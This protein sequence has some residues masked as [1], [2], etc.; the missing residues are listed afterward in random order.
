MVWIPAGEQF[1]MGSP[2]D[3]PR[4][5]GDEGL[6]DVILSSGYWMG[7]FE[8]S[9]AQWNRFMGP[10]R[11]AGQPEVLDHPDSPVV[12]VSWYEAVSFPD[13]LSEY[14]GHEYRLPTEYEW[15]WACRAGS[16]SAFYFGASP[17]G[18]LDHGWYS[19][20]ALSAGERF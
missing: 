6:H 3:E 12:F 8:V 11:G 7:K 2:L 20:N 5:S 14:T 18:L 16:Q 9:K 19:L 1:S 15:E 13:R 4:R 17:A 10:Y